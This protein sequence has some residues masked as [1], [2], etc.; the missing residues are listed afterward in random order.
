MELFERSTGLGTDNEL[1]LPTY[2][3]WRGMLSKEPEINYNKL[4]T[5]ATHS[6]KAKR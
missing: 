1:K 4:I 6:I 2:E 5:E 3:E